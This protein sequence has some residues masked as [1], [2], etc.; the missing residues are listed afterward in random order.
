MPRR[1]F[2]LFAGFA[3]FALFA[4]LGQRAQAFAE[5][6]LPASTQRYRIEAEL[7]PVRQRVTGKLTLHFTNTS[8]AGLEALLFH[9]YLNAFRDA[10]SVF[11]RESHGSLRG[12]RAHS[13]GRI[14]LESLAVDGEELLPKAERTL[15]PEDQ[16][17]LSVPLKRALAAGAHAEVQIRFTAQL[18]KLFA[19]S[20]YAGEFF[21][22]A[23]WFPKLAKLERDGRFAGFPYHGLGE[24]YADFA[25]YD[26]SLRVPANFQVGAV[27]TQL[28]DTREKNTRL[29]RYR[30]TH[31]HD[32][33]WFTAPDYVVTKRKLAGTAV[34]FLA[35][36]GYALAQL[37]H[38]LVVARGLAYY[39]QRYG[40]YPYPTLTVV[41]PPRGAEGA[42]GMEYPSLIVSAGQWLP[43]P[44]AP[45]LSGAFV[46][47]AR[48]RPPMVLRCARKQRGRISRA[49]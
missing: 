44:F 5:G 14:E 24:F 19:R 25:D 22:V 23:Q 43:A 6:S 13:N 18:P 39:A 17:Q 7:D 47:R 34:T 33:A 29:L 26:V 41:I 45:S 15:L 48:A 1:L 8:T 40:A 12:V 27:G 35:P 4:S 16:T 10:N 9:L 38:E 2:A 46:T 11:M 42:A 36:A 20:G 31:V 37:E 30:A 21:A 3:L 28:S 49:R 32:M